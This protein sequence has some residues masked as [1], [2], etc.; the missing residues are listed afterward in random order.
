MTPTKTLAD[1]QDIDSRRDEVLRRLRQ[2]VAALSAGSGIAA[3]R[4]A[5]EAADEALSEIEAKLRSHDLERQ[6]LRDRIK[7]EEG[8]LY[9]GKVKSPK[10][11]QNLQLEI[12]SLKRRLSQLD[13]TA[14]EL[15]VARDEAAEA[16]EQA[17]RHVAELEESTQAR[18]QEL[19]QKKQQLAVKA[20]QLGA[21]REDVAGEL[22]APVLARYEQIRKKKEGVAVAKL[23]G[24]SC[25]VCGMQLPR[26]TAEQVREGNAL[27]T[28]PGCGRIVLP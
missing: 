25:E 17:H 8:K 6:G 5:A 7:T 15:M 23:T 10:E 22:G 2:V 21:N 20:R 14:L 3:A 13:D 1:L 4:Q 11:L 18:T 27:V 9:G 28:C 26:Q 16:A 19:E 12:A 24:D